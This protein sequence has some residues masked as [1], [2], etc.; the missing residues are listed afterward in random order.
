MA[1]MSKYVS[2]TSLCSTSTALRYV[3]HGYCCMATGHLRKLMETGS[4]YTAR[5]GMYCTVQDLRFSQTVVLKSTIFWNITQYNPL[6]VNLHFGETYHLHLQGRRISRA[7]NQRESRW[8][9]ELCWFPARLILR[10]WRWRRYV[11]PKR[12]LTFNGLYCVISQKT[13]LFITTAVRTLNPIQ[14]S[15]TLP[16]AGRI[17]NPQAGSLL[18]LL[19]QQYRKVFMHTDYEF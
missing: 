18:P 5:A 13:V 4:A 6:R 1:L 3:L 12:R 9:A 15:I 7:K 14:F 11:L 10:P 17:Q 16:I 2:R 8:Q 19:L